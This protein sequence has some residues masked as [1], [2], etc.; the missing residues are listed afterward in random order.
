MI[1]PRE[2]GV[3]ALLLTREPN[4]Q[5]IDEYINE[6]SKICKQLNKEKVYEMVLQLENLN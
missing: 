3:F 5:F 4:M 1:S 2:E 6:V